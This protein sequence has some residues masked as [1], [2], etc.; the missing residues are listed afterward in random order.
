VTAKADRK[1]IYS[2]PAI[3]GVIEVTLEWRLFFQIRSTNHGTKPRRA[4]VEQLTAA[5]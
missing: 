3:S 5:P 4:A 1:D 2:R